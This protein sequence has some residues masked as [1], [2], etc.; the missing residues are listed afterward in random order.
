MTGAQRM[1]FSWS[2]GRGTI[3]INISASKLQG[4]EFGS[5]WS[6]SNTLA[7]SHQSS[8]LPLPQFLCYGPGKKEIQVHGLEKNSG[9]LQLQ[10]AR[11]K[12]MH[13]HHSKP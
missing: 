4:S 7:P 2:D 9:V 13:Q 6:G 1:F 11:E 8:A 12:G 5:P 3:K 10:V